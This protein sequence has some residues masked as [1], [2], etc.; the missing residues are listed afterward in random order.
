MDVDQ[1]LENKP[2]STKLPPYQTVMAALVLLIVTYLFFSGEIYRLYA[3]VLFLFYSLTNRMWVSVILLGVFQ[4]F[5]LI[6]LRIIRLIRQDNLKEFQETIDKYNQPILQKQQLHRNFETGNKFFLFYLTDFFIQL[7]TFLSIGRLFL[8]DFYAHHIAA[9]KLYDFV[10]YPEYPIK[11]TVFQIPYVAVTKTIDL[12]WFWVVFFLSLIILIQFLIALVGHI[13]HKT[14][15]SPKDP[16]KY[17]LAYLLI[18]I[19]LAI[20]VVKNF[21]VGFEMRL[22]TGDVSVPNRALNTI[23]AI[24]TFAT[25]LWFGSQRIIRKGKLAR[26]RDVD[27]QIIDKTQ[28]KMFS[29]SV[30]DSTLVGLGAYFITNHIPSAFELSIF[31]LE[32]IS[33]IS[34][35]TLD[36]FILRL[37]RGGSR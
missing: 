21:P 8:T 2:L 16:S 14:T 4:T 10:P 18:G 5:L 1:R 9:N 11:D 32:V 20:V 36:K 37:K 28:Q 17:T 23:T 19:V 24:A 15:Q 22:F 7:A 27:Q 3:S 29:Q 34:P 12:G 26:S 31:T 13:A 35:F 6:P 33:L 30:F 25:M